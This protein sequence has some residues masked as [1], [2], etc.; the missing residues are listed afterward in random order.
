MSSNSFT[1]ITGASGGIGHDLAMIAA[2]KGKNLV[3]VARSADKL[4]TKTNANNWNFI[5]G[6]VY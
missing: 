3:L 1:L 5:I 4:D 2:G 6:I